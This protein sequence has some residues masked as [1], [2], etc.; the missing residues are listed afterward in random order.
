MHGYI[1][2]TE[3]VELLSA[4]LFWWLKMKIYEWNTH[5]KKIMK[6]RGTMASNIHG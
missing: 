6:Y 3:E 1:I 5:K 2:Q 4:P